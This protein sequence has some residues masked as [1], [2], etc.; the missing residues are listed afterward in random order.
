MFS[1][2]TPVEMSSSRGG[3]GNKQKIEF[4]SRIQ[5]TTG[6]FFK[7]H[8]CAGT[9]CGVPSQGIAIGGRGMGDVNRF[10]FGFSLV[11]SVV[12]LVL[13]AAVAALVCSPLP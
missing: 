9:I 4:F 8:S 5:L 7:L 11:G 13:S 6:M 1:Q 3:T 2:R 10:A 12:I